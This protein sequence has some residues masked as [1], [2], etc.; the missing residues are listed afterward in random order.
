MTGARSRGRSN[1][2]F[3]ESAAGRSG[4]PAFRRAAEL[5]LTPVLATADPARHAGAAAA[6]VRIAVCATGS[7]GTLARELRSALDG[8]AGVTTL[9]RSH[10]VAA[11]RAAA[12]LGLP[13][14]PP[15]AVAA[16]HDRARLRARLAAARLPSP[17]FEV[18]GPDDDLDS[19][20]VTALSRI[21]TPC[22]VRPALGGP[23]GAAL[24][25]TF[26]EVTDHCRKVLS[27][28]PGPALIEG[29]LPGPE[30]GVETAGS[31]GVHHCVGITSGGA[32]RPP[33]ATARQPD[34]VT[35][36]PHAA[37]R[38]HVFPAPVP[39]DVADEL[40]ATA[41]GALA[42]VGVTDGAAHVTMRLVGGRAYVVGIDALPAGGVIPGLVARACGFDLIDA[43]LRAAV[44]LGP[45]PLPGRPTPGGR[46]AVAVPRQERWIPPSAIP[47][48]P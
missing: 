32:A 33:Y 7:P 30:F 37:T 46:P 48:S 24:C 22:V 4:M 17:A 13:G 9:S 40:T 5:G 47:T 16:C 39:P 20:V 35:R 29:Y 11:A 23:P 34:T 43:H 21:A 41:S 15:D 25:E 27:S 31:G 12:D 36:Q 26:A 44:G 10:A 14:N 42:A 45:L 28:G 1:L 6:G 38:E 18:A 19:R 3:V 2:V 8:I